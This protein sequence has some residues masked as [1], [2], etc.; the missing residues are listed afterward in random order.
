SRSGITPTWA[1]SRLR[2]GVGLGRA[3]ERGA[4]EVPEPGRAFLGRPRQC[5]D[6]DGV[7]VRDDE[8]HHDVGIVLR[9]GG[10]ARAGAIDS[11]DMV[12][13]EPPVWRE[14]QL[15][16]GRVELR[17]AEAFPGVEPQAA[18]R[19]RLRTHANRELDH[20]PQLLYGV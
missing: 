13:D 12:L 1:R 17:E 3:P 2:P 20:D 18:M 5:T 19:V 16:L 11:A 7:R 14:R 9:I 10:G 6:A 4:T 15:G 8:A